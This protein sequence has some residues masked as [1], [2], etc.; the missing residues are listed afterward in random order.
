MGVAV[1]QDWLYLVSPTTGTLCGT[2]HAFAYRGDHTLSEDLGRIKVGCTTVGRSVCH[3]A[4]RRDALFTA[5]R[6]ALKP[7]RSDPID[8]P[9]SLN[10]LNGATCR[11]ASWTFAP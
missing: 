10:D 11:I 4:R 9:L 2:D 6:M 1:R 8:V 7:G 5:T 3:A